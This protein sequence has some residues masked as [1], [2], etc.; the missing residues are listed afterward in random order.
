ML[1]TS[2]LQHEQVKSQ[3]Q[4]LKLLWDQGAGGGGGGGGAKSREPTT[5]IWGRGPRD[6]KNKYPCQ[7]TIT[8]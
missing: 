1:H 2:T 7:S 5:D 6:E 8:L 3:K 4:H